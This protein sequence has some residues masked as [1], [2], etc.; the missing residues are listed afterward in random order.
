MFDRFIYFPPQASF[1]RQHC[2]SPDWECKDLRLVEP[3]LPLPP[4]PVSR[5]GFCDIVVL[6]LIDA[7][8]RIGCCVFVCGRVRCECALE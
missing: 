4:P 5:T 6:D 2:A 3:P 1:I 8:C 7:V